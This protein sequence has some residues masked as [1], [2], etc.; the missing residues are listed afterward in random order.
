[1]N[2]LFIHGRA[3]E[4]YTQEELLNGWTAALK[5]SFKNAQLEFPDD[6]NLILPYY[7]KEL[8][9]Q[10]DRYKK[11]IA[12]GV[13]QMRSPGEQLKEIDNYEKELVEIMRE[14]ANISKK[15]VAAEVAAEQQDRGPENWWATLAIT[16]LLDKHLNSVSNGCVK[17]ATDDVVTYL[18]VPK[19]RKIINDYYFS[20]L[21][22]EPTIIIAHSLGT[23]VAYDILRSLDPE[24]FDVRGLITIGSPL[25][26]K[27]VQRQLHPPMEYPK[28]LK[29]NWVNVFDRR[30]IVSLNSLNRKNFRVSPEIFN[31]EVDNDSDN[32]HKIKEYLSN[33]L[34]AK[35][36]SEMMR[37]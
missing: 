23:I 29:G 33:M 20:A 15:E 6:L 13:Y 3:Q 11:D 36:I 19:A 22:K 30:D 25:G 21:T 24:A 7:G 35:T 34:I 27:T 16:R 14:N 10:R 18:V 4:E 28:S 17:R 37:V 32:R 26:V 8:I 9:I 5:M 31:H 12:D 1:M 2:L